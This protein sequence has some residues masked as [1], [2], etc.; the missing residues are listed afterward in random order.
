MNAMWRLSWPA[1]LEQLLNMMV[2][3]ADTAMVGALGATATAAVAVNSSC[4]W[5]V[6][7]LLGGVAIGYSV[8]VSNAVGAG[9]EGRVK[10][11]IRQSIMAVFV[12]GILFLVIFQLLAPH[13]PKWLGV[14]DEVLPYAISYL[15]YYTLALPF[16]ASSTILSSML[17]CMGNTK[18]PLYFNMGANVLNVTLNFFFIYPTRTLTVLG[19]DVT[20]IG[21]DMGVKGAAIASAIAMVFVGVSLFIAVTRQGDRFQI[22]LRDKFK[23]DLDIIRQA[24]RLGVPSAV[25]RSTINLGQIAITA[26]V[27]SLGTVSLAAHQIAVTAEGICYLPSFGISA[28]GLAFVGQ[29]VGAKSKEDAQ[30]Y[31]TL[32]AQF[33]ALFSG[34]MGLG[35][36]VFSVPLA[37]IFNSDPEV[38]AQAA[39]MLR[40][41]AVCEPFFALFIVIANTLRAAH[42]VHMPMI[43]GLVCM[44]GVRICLSLF[45]VHVLHLGLASVWIAMTIDLILR[46]ILCTLR[47]RSGKWL[48]FSGLE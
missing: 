8:Q 43:T 22:S 15:R 28:A 19:C 12:F 39:L 4:I 30:A 24:I 10:E 37:S 41:V 9:E 13:V 11:L 44:W 5:L 16:T 25:E 3:Y 7:G 1:I 38:V 46:G 6:L 40:I 33:G 29:S 32:A 23:P 48:K 26:L 20:I 47:W 14:D 42:D 35:L 17:R 36:F 18:T 21:A 45:F 27:A 2:S 31:G 34:V